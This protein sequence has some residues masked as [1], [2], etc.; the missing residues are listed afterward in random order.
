M[1]MVS[2]LSTDVYKGMLGLWQV[3]SGWGLRSD[4]VTISLAI[5]R[6]V[7]FELKREC[8][9]VNICECVQTF[10]YRR[11]YTHVHMPTWYLSLNIWPL[12]VSDMLVDG[13]FSG[14][15]GEGVTEPWLLDTQVSGLATE[16]GPSGLS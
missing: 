11:T 6:V 10:E 5:L 16:A 7:G 4:F 14:D 3:G 8:V 2:W 15:G 9:H 12:T 13:A 1:T